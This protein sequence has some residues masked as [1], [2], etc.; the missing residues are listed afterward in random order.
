MSVLSKTI[1]ERA[2]QSGSGW[3]RNEDVD[4]SNVDTLFAILAHAK[5]AVPT[6]TANAK[7]ISK[8]PQSVVISLKSSTGASFGVYRSGTMSGTGLPEFT[9]ADLTEQDFTAGKL[10]RMKEE[11]GLD[12]PTKAE[13]DAIYA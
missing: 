10:F 6:F 12:E 9:P 2:G 7:A 5:H 13:L 3:W 4:T 8:N 11:Q 1:L